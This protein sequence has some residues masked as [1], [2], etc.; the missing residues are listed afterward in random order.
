[1]PFEFLKTTQI[2]KKLLPGV[3]NEAADLFAA[4]VWDAANLSSG[5]FGGDYIKL[6][7]TK[8]TTVNG[9][10]SIVGTQTRDLNTEDTDTGNHCDIAYALPYDAQ[11]ANFT[12][13][14]DSTPITLTG[15]TS[16]ATAKLVADEDA[17]AT[18]TLY[19]VTIT[20]TFADNETITDGVGGSATSNI[21]SGVAG[22]GFY[23]AAGTYHVSII[24][25]AATVGRHKII[26]EGS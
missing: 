5:Q 24:S 25:V 12:V 26:L 16:G 17:G 10:S 20:G 22:K 13:S 11:T 9:G 23:I 6:T 19:V 7:D 1:M 15:G 18:G 21:P 2:V 4:Y 14:T 8:A 3:M